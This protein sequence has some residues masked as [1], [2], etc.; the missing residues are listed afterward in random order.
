MP[1]SIVCGNCSAKMKAPDT[2]AGKRVK[3]PKCSTPILV[4]VAEDDFEIV[5]DEPRKPLKSAVKP[6]AVDDDDE[7]DDRPEKK[8][9]RRD[10]DD[11]DDDDEEERPRKKKNATAKKKGVPV[12]AFAIAGVAFVAVIGVVAALVL[13][14]GK[15]ESPG[16]PG[17]LA[18]PGGTLGPSTPAGYTAVRET[19]GG[20]AVFLPGD[21][22]KT[23]AKFNGQN[24]SELGHFG[25]KVDEVRDDNPDGK[26]AGASSRPLAAGAKPGTD[27]N[28]LMQLLTEI[29]SFVTES[30]KI[31]VVSKRAVT[32]GGKPG[33]EIKVKEKAKQ[34][35]KPGDNGF[36]DKYD[37]EERER[38]A[39]DGMFTV[40]YFTHDG[41][42]MYSIRISQKRAFPSDDVL[43]I[44]AESFSFL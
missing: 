10:H 13:I 15:P 36:W 33:I 11:D 2:A 12:W 35:G 4:P 19:D 32:L 24:L 28:A 37:L 9:R 34:R 8:S 7:V 26:Q 1:I 18:G 30:E 17:A 3:C 43:K 25:W 23:N 27:Q 14:G 42:R 22:K 5:D 6:V 21:A 31:A 16:T 20:F 38:V 39:K 40:T 29:D 41:N 44:I